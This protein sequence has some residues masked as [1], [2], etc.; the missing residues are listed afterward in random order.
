[1]EEVVEDEVASYA[2]GCLDVGGV[3]GEEMPHVSDLHEENCEPIK[4]RNQSIQGER[5]WVR[6]IVSP[7]GLPPCHFIIVGSSK[8]IVNA[9]D[10][11]DDPGDDRED[12]VGPYCLH[13][14]VFPPREW[15]DIRHLD[16]WNDDLE[17]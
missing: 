4:R 8:G 3:G 13:W 1:L 11:I 10:D 6:C 12:F 14:V 9:C 5:R 15:V 17:S 2:C 7:D 16:G